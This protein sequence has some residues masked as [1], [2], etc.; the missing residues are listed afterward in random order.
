[1]DALLPAPA[2]HVMRRDANGGH[3]VA[4]GC[5]LLIIVFADL[6]SIVGVT[7]RATIEHR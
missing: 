2:S 1:M 7:R 6:H 5:E 4:L 3:S